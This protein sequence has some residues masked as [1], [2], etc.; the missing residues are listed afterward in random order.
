MADSEREAAADRFLKEAATLA[1]LDARNTVR[2]FDYGVWNDRPYL[3]ME[4][5]AGQRLTSLIRQHGTLDPERAVD[6]AVQMCRSLREAHRLGIVHRDLKPDNILVTVDE[7]GELVKVVD[8][9]LVTRS[10]ATGEDTGEGML[11]GTPRYMA[12]EQMGNRSVDAR[13]DIYSLGLLI[14][15]ML[16]GGWPY[17]ATGTSSTLLAHL[18]AEPATVASR[19]PDGRAVPACVEWTI[20]TALE[21]SPSDRFG[22][23]DELRVALAACRVA[24]KGGPA[25]AQLTPT[26]RNGTCVVPDALLEGGSEL[27]TEISLVSV[28]PASSS[29]TVPLL[30]VMLSIVVVVLGLAVL[31]LLADPGPV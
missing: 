11:V 3:V 13:A 15:R 20:A 27:N 30:K 22:S 14:Y 2:I 31:L 12:P 10:G 29:A 7:D 8:F 26:L 6:L 25:L 18:E 16:T 23:V 9:G 19:L 5:I 4:Y 17:E 1:R 21:K 28:P 24:L